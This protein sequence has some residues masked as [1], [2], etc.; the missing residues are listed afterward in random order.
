MLFTSISFL[1]Y[2]LPIVIILY[3]IV[4]KKFKNFILFLSS[5]FFYFCGEPIYTFLMIG[6]IFIAYVGARYL[7][8]H[9]KKS[10]LVSLLA[11]HIGA[12]GLFKYSDFTIN[13]INQIFGSKIPLLKLALPIGI[14]F[15]TFQIIS[16]VVDVYRGKVKAQ[17]SFLKLATYVSLFP[18]LIAGPIVRYETIEKELDN[19][20]S[21]FENF[22]YG[23]RRFVIGLGK[24]VLIANMLGE[25]C[26]VFST[27]NEKSILFYWI[28]AISYSLQ[29]YFDFSAY[30]DMAI[31]LGRMFGFHFL[32]NFNYPYI[33]K[34]ITEFWRRWH[35]SLS[36]WFRDY[37]YIP[38][39]GNRKGTIILVRNIFIV[40]ALTGIWHG[41]NWTFVIWGLMFGIMLIIEKLFLTKHLEKMPSILQRIYVLFTVMISFI[42]FNANSIGEAWNNIIGLFGANG[43]SLINASTVYYLKSYLVV[44]VIAII[45]STP[46]L[47][48]IIEKLKIKT[49]ANKIINL[50]EPIAMASILIIVTAYLVDNSY[51]P[52]LYFRF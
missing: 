4:P 45:G 16:Y 20:T 38:L 3:F 6:E 8:K 46:L 42:I 19:R 39:G 44:L 40:W 36:S 13:N 7:E 47:K 49:N 50:L 35:M 52:F 26:D 23:V 51:N 48:N 12:L 25:L 15:Y 21:N 28:F 29:I 24:K 31:G 5:I 32:E 43:E 17:K 33:S 30:S 41:A 9:R 10:I 14:S 11:I 34:S 27:T 37:V 1:Y 18:Q 22:A 2:F